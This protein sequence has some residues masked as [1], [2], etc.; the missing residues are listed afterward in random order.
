MDFSRVGEKLPLVIALK[1]KHPAHGEFWIIG[2]DHVRRH[3]DVTAFPL[4]ASGEQLMGAVA[5]FWE[6]RKA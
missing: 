1:E 2:K 5:I 6:D 4:I 3:L